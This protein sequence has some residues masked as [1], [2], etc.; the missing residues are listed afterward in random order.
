MKL[1]VLV[2]DAMGKERNYKDVEHIAIKPLDDSNGMLALVLTLE[3]K[4]VHELYGREVSII[5]SEG[6]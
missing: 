1:I 5:H 3:T 6:V 2:T 4:T